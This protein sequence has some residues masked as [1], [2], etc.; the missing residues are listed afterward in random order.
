MNA[1]IHNLLDDDDDYLDM[2][3]YERRNSLMLGGNGAYFKWALPQESRAFYALGDLAVETFLG[4]NPHQNFAGE[5]AK[6]MTEVLPVNPVE[7]W[8]AFMPSVAIPFIE[9][10]VNED[11]KGAPIYNE[12]KWL[13]EEERER[14]AKWSSAYKGTGRIY[15]EMSKALNSISGGDEYDAGRINLQPEIMEHLV[16]SAFG[17][18]IRTGDKF[19]NSIMAAIDPE[20]NVTVSQLPFVNRILTI[21][22]ERYKNVHV[23]EVFA[24]YQ[25]EAEHVDRLD[26][27]YRKDKND[28]ARDRLRASEEW[29]WLKIYDSYKKAIKRKQ[30]EIRAAEG[31]AERQELMKQLDELKREMIKEI[32]E[33]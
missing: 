23:N 2:P 5:A 4:R 25:A 33:L 21:N 17:G 6:I 3:Q 27:M 15:V 26:K 8:K 30:D 7:G 13:S 16:Q 18:T 32:S 9:I 20:E 11:Y 31:T 19:I 28:E 12:Q 22:D 24:Y 1:M 10:L 14:T 29:Q